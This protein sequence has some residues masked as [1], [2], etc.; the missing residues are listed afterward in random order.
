M[1]IVYG[2]ADKVVDVGYTQRVPEVGY[3]GSSEV[4]RFSIPG[5]Y[6]IGW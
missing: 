5:S 4:M 6:T 3:P 1:L 2:S